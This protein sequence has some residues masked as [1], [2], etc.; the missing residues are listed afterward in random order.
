METKRKSLP[1]VKDNCSFEGYDASSLM[2]ETSKLRKIITKRGTLEILIPLCC[3]TEPVRHKE[4]KQALKG[5]SSK[6]LAIRLKELEKSGVL[7]RLSY[8]E[9]PPRVEYKLTN[10]GQELV[11]SMINLLQWMKKWSRSK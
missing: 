7:E 11:E 10:K 2:S 3:T 4:F 9:I 5:I 6:T 8:N 1:M